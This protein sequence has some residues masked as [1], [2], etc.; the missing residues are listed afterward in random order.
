[1]DSKSQ[2]NLHFLVAKTQKHI[3]ESLYTYADFVRM[4]KNICVHVQLESTSLHLYMHPH[5]HL[6]VHVNLI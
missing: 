3:S 2:L 5:L 6:H 1:M 4:R